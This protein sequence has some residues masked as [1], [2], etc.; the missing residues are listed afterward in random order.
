MARV[1]SN[2]LDLTKRVD[3]VAYTLEEPPFFATQHM[4]SYH[5][6]QLLKKEGVKVDFMLSLEMIGFY[7][8]E[9]NS[10]TFP[11][12]AM[13]FLYPTTGDFIAIIGRSDQKGLNEVK[14]GIQRMSKVLV[15]SFSGPQSLEGVD[16]SDHRNYWKFGFRA[17]M[18]T[19]TSFYR[20]PNYHKS[21]DTIDTLDFV[22]MSQVVEGTTSWVLGVAGG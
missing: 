18:L 8:D 15:E 3:I 6:A 22:K 7:S 2:Q 10:Q 5:H 16:Y 9:P 21:S 17:F 12:P 13:R 4:G 19:D 14:K 1:L 11:I 20:N